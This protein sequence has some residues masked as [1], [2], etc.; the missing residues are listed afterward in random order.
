MGGIKQICFD[1]YNSF[2]EILDDL[3]TQMDR[4]DQRVR[5]ETQHIDVVSH[6]DNTCGYWVVI[7]LLFISIIV[8]VS[9]P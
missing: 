2:P 9:L 8:V 6:K 5:D 3:D 1:Q 4:T 7:I